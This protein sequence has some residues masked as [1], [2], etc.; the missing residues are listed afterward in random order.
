MDKWMM[1]T[2]TDKMNE[3]LR[4]CVEVRKTKL[5]ERYRCSQT[6]SGGW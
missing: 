4:R 5:K 2:E 6:F 1:N 3:T